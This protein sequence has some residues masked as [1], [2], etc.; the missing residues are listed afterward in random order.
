LGT[1]DIIYH[2]N[3][4]S[5]SFRPTIINFVKINRYFIENMTYI[6]NI[7]TGNKLVFGAWALVL[8][9]SLGFFFTENVRADNATP[10]SPAVTVA[11]EGIA[12]E[13]VLVE[14]VAPEVTIEALPIL[15]PQLSTDKEDYAA[16]EKVTIWGKFF[17]SVKSLFL[18][19]TGGFPD[20]SESVTHVSDTITTN[21]EGDFAYEYQLDG[22]YR[23][24]YLVEAFSALSGAL[25]SQ[26]TFTDAP[27]SL[28]LDQCKNGGVS[29]PV[30]CDFEGSNTGWGSGNANANNAHLREGLSQAYRLIGKNV[31]SGNGQTIVYSFDYTK[32]GKVAQDFPTHYNNMDTTAVTPTVGTSF[33]GIPNSSQVFPSLTIGTIPA[34]VLATPTMTKSINAQNAFYVANPALSSLSMWGGT[35]TGISYSFDGTAANVVSGDTKV[36][37]HIT[38]DKATPGDLLVSMGGHISHRNDYLPS[39]ETAIFISGSPYHHTAVSASF[40]NVGNQDMQLAALAIIVQ[41]TITIHKVCNGGSGPTFG[42]GITGT[43]PSSPSTT[44]GNNTGAI[45]VT[46]G[47]YSVTENSPLLPGWTLT[48]TT[49]TK[50]GNSSSNSNV[51]L[52]GGDALVCTF[53]NTFTPDGTITLIKNVINNNGGTA[54][55]N[56]F[57]LTTG[58]VSVTSGQ[59]LVVPANTP[60]AI[61]EAGL[62]GYAFVDIT[63]AGCPANLGGTVSVSAGQNITCTI[64][65]DDIAPSLTLNKIVVNDNGGTAL[66]SSWT[67]TADGGTAGTLSGPGAA[68]SADVVSGATFKAGTYALSESTGPTGYTPS[69]WSC[70]GTG[71]Q[72]GSNITLALGQS[73]VCTITNDDIAPSLTLNKIVVND[74]GGTALESAWTLTANGGTAGTLSGPG[75]AGSTDVQSGATFK[76]GTYALS[77]SAGPSGYTASAWTCTNSVTVNGSNQITL[78]LGQTTVCSITNTA[79][80][81]TLKLVKTVTNDN[82][83]NK[84][85]VDWTLTA[86]GTNGFSD[87]GNSTTFHTVNAGV[88]YVLSESVVAGYT[89]GAWSC[90]GGTLVGSTI[91]LSLGQNITCT[92]NNDDNAPSLTLNK[93]TN[94]S[95]GGTAPESSWTLTADGGAAGTLSGP[96]AAGSADVVS[97]TTFQAGTYA[98]SESAAPFG[99]TNGASYSC[100]KN[101]GGAVLGNSITLAVGDTAICSITNTDIAPRLTIIKNVINDDG[102]VAVADDFTMLVSGVSVSTASFQGSEVGDTIT[103]SAGV[104]SVDEGDH[105]GYIKTLSA[106]CS[107]TI[108]VG[109]TKTCTITNNDIPSPTRTQGFWQTHTN[110]ASTT[111]VGG[112]SLQIGNHTI[113][114]PPKLFS[115]FYSSIPKTSTGAKRTALDQ[116]RMQMLQQWLAAKLNCAA[117]GCSAGTQTLLT[118]A[119]TAWTSGPVSLIKSFA[120]QLD[121]YNNS[122]DALPISGQG[123]ATPKNSQSAAS[124]A[125]TFWDALP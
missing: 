5:C 119:A 24:D 76:A 64:T 12:P 72:V 31:P 124:S 63:G 7:F 51:S 90:P 68:G 78:G 121:A 100:V 11:E 84:N 107:G 67:L 8:M 35:I 47:T 102:N 96:G 37:V 125:S 80:A 89:A 29:S 6:R 61:N 77:E 115:G 88:G 82:G 28:K 62:A 86:T 52:A 92:I 9:L 91:T 22:V 60:K 43:T 20:G 46:A 41:P 50:N 83:G 32:G 110:Y 57:G 2:R 111:F 39:P 45:N 95:Y 122:N 19:I 16:Y 27:T 116:A 93:I 118:E 105:A 18:K 113:N 97:G 13:V 75:A 99:Y 71:N 14:E 4:P 101:G 123:K 85:P 109:E 23:P 38:F 103:L 42:F 34:S 44:C 94:Y 73:A 81:P 3:Q 70:T 17:G 106:D 21:E 15:T 117:F 40:T 33:S 30:N 98:L 54:G 59:A 25:L 120:S 69:S 36:R 53:T 79:V 49:C 66:E 87:A 74:N 108:G 55:V 48:D 58:G 10:T 65:N 104:Y 26:V 112:G 1:K 56:D 114:T